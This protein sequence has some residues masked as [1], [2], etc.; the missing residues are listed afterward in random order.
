MIGL[1]KN[2]GPETTGRE[3]PRV[4]SSGTADGYGLAGFKF[5]KVVLGQ[6]PPRVTGIK[7]YDKNV[8]RDEIIL[9]LVSFSQRTTFAFQ[10][11]SDV[12]FLLRSNYL[13]H[14]TIRCF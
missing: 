13:S 11:C 9:D 2:P 1:F 14:F 12:I 8:G 3:K 10:S 7:V 5:E 6:I 4:V